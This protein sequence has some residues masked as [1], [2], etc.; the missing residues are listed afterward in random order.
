[1]TEQSVVEYVVNSIWQLPLLAAMAWLL[2]WIGKPAAK[3]QHRIWL[4]TLALSILLPLLRQGV[5]PTRNWMENYAKRSHPGLRSETWGTPILVAGTSVGPTLRDGTAKDGTPAPVSTLRLSQSAVN[6]LLALYLI[7]VMGRFVQLAFAW[8]GA[9]R[10]VRLALEKKLSPAQRAILEDCCV[11]LRA[12]EPRMLISAEIASPMT[13]G[14]MRPAVLLPERFADNTESE[15]AAMLCHELA[16]V[17]CRDTLANWVC[18]LGSLPIAYHPATYALHRRIRR[19]RELV[20][21]AMAAAAMDSATGYAQCLV[22]LAQRMLEGDRR[23]QQAQAAGL[24]DHDVLE[25]RIMRLLERKNSMST[26]AR[27]LRAG[28]AM[29]LTAAVIT[30]AA[31]FHVTPTVVNAAEANTSAGQINSDAGNAA[32]T[33]A[34]PAVPAPVAS[35]MQQAVPTH[36]IVPVHMASPVRAAVPTRGCSSRACGIDRAGI[37]ARASN[38]SSASCG[39][40]ACFYPDT[41][42]RCSTGN[43]SC[44]RS[45]D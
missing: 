5:F 22:T 19:S 1:M 13:I 26:R 36:G 15:M 39:P 21:D 6:W 30:T 24:F 23:A 18:Q 12:R 31:V 40:N 42:R 28:C 44:S 35:A 32:V 25:E 4:M 45:A 8:R 43:E 20:C 17:R 34:A 38:R 41:D 37:G 2:M 33:V 11:K 9:R 10:L 14:V 16:H 29:A 27:I 7:V 3:T